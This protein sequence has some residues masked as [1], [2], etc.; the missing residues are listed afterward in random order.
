MYEQWK[1]NLHG[2]ET[3][4]KLNEE[5]S[6]TTAAIASATTQKSKAT[7]HL[8]PADV[9]LAGLSKEQNTESCHTHDKVIVNWENQADICG[10]ERQIW[11]YTMWIPMRAWKLFAK[12]GRRLANRAER[13]PQLVEFAVASP[14]FGGHMAASLWESGKCWS[15]PGEMH[16]RIYMKK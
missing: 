3:I 9:Q 2:I 1:K 8:L 7:I 4:Q 13:R 14:I 15:V 12:H 5:A 16:I 11:H 10:G 6:T